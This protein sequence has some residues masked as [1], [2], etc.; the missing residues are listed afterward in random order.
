MFN[1][2]VDR[3]WTEKKELTGF[4]PPDR[5]RQWKRLCFDLLKK[6]VKNR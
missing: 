5:P 4:S 1:F 6:S 3:F 2:R